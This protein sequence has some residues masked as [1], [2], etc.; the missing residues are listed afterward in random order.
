MDYSIQIANEMTQDKENN[1]VISVDF[2]EKKA[3]NVYSLN[4]SNNYQLEIQNDKAINKK[5]SN[6]TTSKSKN[7]AKILYFTS[8]A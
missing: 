7:N 8:A 5:I 4:E 1:Y 6:R 2:V 3:I